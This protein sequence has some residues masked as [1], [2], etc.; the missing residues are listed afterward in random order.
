MMEKV[1]LDEQILAIETTLA[2][3]RGYID[4]LRHLVKKKQR[5]E[6]WLNIAERQY[7]KLVAILNTLKWLKKNEEKIKFALGS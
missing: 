3:Q 1:S 2:N 4:N 7:P 6:I 5:E